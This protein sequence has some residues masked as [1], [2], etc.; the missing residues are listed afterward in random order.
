MTGPLHAI[1]RE[2]VDA[3]ES[4]PVNL[5]LEQVG[6]VSAGAADQEAD[7]VQLQALRAASG[8]ASDLCS[9]RDAQ[10]FLTNLR[11]DLKTE[12]S[13]I[14]CTNTA[15]VCGHGT[16]RTGDSTRVPSVGCAAGLWDRVSRR[17]RSTDA[18]DLSARV[19]P[20]N[21]HGCLT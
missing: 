15:R 11:P 18:H 3:W 6:Y 10:A 4:D 1:L 20:R 9:G 2:S 5:G 14:V 12:S 7:H 13:D 8:Y 16:W 17:E 21:H 19:I